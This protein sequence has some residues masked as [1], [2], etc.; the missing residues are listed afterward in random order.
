MVLLWY[1]CDIPVYYILYWYSCDIV[2]IF[3]FIIFCTDIVVIFL[4][5][6]FCTGIVVILLWYSCIKFWYCRL[7]LYNSYCVAFRTLLLWIWFVKNFVK[8]PFVIFNVKCIIT[9][10]TYFHPIPI[11]VLI[12]VHNIFHMLWLILPSWSE[13]QSCYSEWC[14]AYSP[15]RRVS[16]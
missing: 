5:I 12:Y 10:V 15:Y 6:I 1:F 3:L 14:S 4:F 9:L 11:L 8:C 13:A 7:W 2:V 16:V